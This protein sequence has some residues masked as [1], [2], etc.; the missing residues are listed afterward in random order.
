MS[1]LPF[2][3]LG[4]TYQQVLA[5]VAVP[6]VASDRPSRPSRGRDECRPSEPLGDSIG[7]AVIASIVTATTK[8]D[9]LSTEGRCP[10]RRLTERVRIA[11]RR[12]AAGPEQD[13]DPMVGSG[14]KVVQLMPDA[15]PSWPGTVTSTPNPLVNGSSGTVCA[16][17][18]SH[19]PG[20][21]GGPSVSSF[22][23]EAKLSTRTLGDP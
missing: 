12:H 11:S 3:V 18:S 20:H 17:Q 23:T 9:G 7:V 6:A 1:I 22:L 15:A 16:Y 5:A 2:A 8:P 4:F 13:D 14:M 21:R 19:Y 10:T